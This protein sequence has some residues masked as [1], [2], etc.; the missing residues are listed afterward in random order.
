MTDKIKIALIA[1][2]TAVSCVAILIYFS[3]YQSCVRA[4]E[5]KLHQDEVEDREQTRAM[6]RNSGQHDQAFLD[7]PVTPPERI[8]A[9]AADH[10]RSSGEETIALP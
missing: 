3:P 10:C 5:A 8:A 6:R 2:L 4:H 7:R 9:L 1:A